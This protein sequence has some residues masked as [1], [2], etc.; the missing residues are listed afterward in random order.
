MAV[1][2]WDWL[3]RDKA[4]FMLPS[5]APV[6]LFEG[7]SQITWI[8]TSVRCLPFV[9]ST[10]LA[11]RVRKL[12]TARTRKNKRTTRMLANARKDQSIPLCRSS[13]AGRMAATWSSS[14]LLIITSVYTAQIQF[15]SF[16]MRLAINEQYITSI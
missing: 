10:V 3:N 12:I 1:S 7:V 4:L 14:D 13:T 6:V 2:Y 15:Y 9:I 8:K 11:A 5:F 16:Q